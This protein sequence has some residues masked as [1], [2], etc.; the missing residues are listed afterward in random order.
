VTAPGAAEYRRLPGRGRTLLGSDTLWIGE[1]HLLLVELRGFTETYRR[2]YF[3]DVQAIILRRTDRAGTMGILLGLLGLVFLA[4][5]TGAGPVWNVVWGS[6]SGLLFLGLAVN[7]A[8]GPSCH[9][10]LRTALQTVRL[11]PLGRL[12]R[13]RR[14]LER[15]RTHIEL[16]QGALTPD[17]RVARARAAAGEEGVAAAPSA[18]APVVP[19]RPPVVGAER[20]TRHDTGRAHETLAYALLFSAIVG[21]V[22]VLYFHITLSVALSVVFLGRMACL[23][24]ALARQHHSD[25]PASLKTFAWTAF[26]FEAAIVILGMVSGV[27]MVFR[28]LDSAVLT[29]PLAIMEKVRGNPLYKVSAFLSSLAWLT[30][31]V[32]GLLL[33]RRLASTRGN[34]WQ[35]LPT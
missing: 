18:A 17:E 33:H 25:L 2:F 20:V 34:T 27:V 16:E 9:C 15:L 22:P 23:V 31:G 8:L 26:G 3:R 29:T 12:R 19:P 24:A 30:L 11:R 4:F 10:V 28:M 13:A 32:W 7:V 35:T 1:D 14:V 5:A 6:V 21:V